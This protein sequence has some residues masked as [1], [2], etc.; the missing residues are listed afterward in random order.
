MAARPQV[1]RAG[2]TALAHRAG[3]VAEHDLAVAGGRWRGLPAPLEPPGEELLGGRFVVPE[4]DRQHRAEA[5][6]GED[7]EE[8]IGDADDDVVRVFV[9]DDDVDEFGA[10]GLRQ[11]PAEDLA[12][13]LE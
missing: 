10:W 1:R 8:V 9:L 2:F 11:V 6:G 7:G 13:G 4:S 3:G 5:G 12:Q